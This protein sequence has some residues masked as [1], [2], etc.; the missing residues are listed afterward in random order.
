LIRESRIN[1]HGLMVE[2]AG[3]VDTAHVRIR[4]CHASKSRGVIRAP[5][6]RKSVLRQ[7]S[8]QVPARSGFVAPKNRRLVST[9]GNT[10]T[11]QHRGQ[12]QPGERETPAL[13]TLVIGSMDHEINVPQTSGRE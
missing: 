13:R 6:H 5:T 10:A 4:M 11:E 1:V 2:I 12:G 3:L 9:T 7:G 8:V